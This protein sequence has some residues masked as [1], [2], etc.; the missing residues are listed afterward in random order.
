MVIFLRHNLWGNCGEFLLILPHVQYSLYRQTLNVISIKF[1]RIFKIQ[2]AF[3]KIIFADIKF[4]EPGE[5][6]K[7]MPNRHNI[8]HKHGAKINFQDQDPQKAR[9]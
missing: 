4:H 9:E 5:F 6:Q 8:H 2:T 1:S 3:L 7:Q